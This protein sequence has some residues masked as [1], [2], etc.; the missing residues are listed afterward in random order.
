MGPASANP[1]AEPQATV[2]ERSRVGKRTPGKA[3]VQSHP[4]KMPRF[5]TGDE[6]GNL[7]AYTSTNEAGSAKVQCSELFV[8]TDK[9]KSVQ[10]LAI[11]KSTVSNIPRVYGESS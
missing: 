4:W 6:L 2:I 8:E 7:K 1:K 9:R 5:I 10:M 11:A 3:S